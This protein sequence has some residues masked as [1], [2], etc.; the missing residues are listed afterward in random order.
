MPTHQPRSVASLEMTLRADPPAVTAVRPVVRGLA[1][2]VLPPERVDDASLA[3]TEAV[4]NAIL[5]AYPGGAGIGEVTVLVRARPGCLRIGVV[6]RGVGFED[7]DR[8]PATTG[9]GL[10]LRLISM[11]ADDVEVESGADGTAV[12]MRFGG[13]D[14]PRPEVSRR[15]RRGRRSSCGAGRRAPT[16]ERSM[17]STARRDLGLRVEH[18]ERATLV[19]VEGDV[20]LAT[21]DAVAGAIAVA[22]AGRP[23]Y[24]VVLEMS[25]VD[26][27]DSTGLRVLLEAARR[28]E[29]AFYVLDPSREVRRMLELTLLAATIQVIPDLSAVGADGAAPA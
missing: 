9:L 14:P 29:P 22:S 2:A 3:V 11:L 4:G 28:P 10:G 12:R 5:H 20:D 26:L 13:G 24:P 19:H 1:R 17:T 21:A 25:G 27:I 6:D 18:D 7:G 16:R 15:G 8:A 23:G